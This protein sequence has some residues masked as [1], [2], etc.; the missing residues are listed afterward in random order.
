MS[1]RTARDMQ[2]DPVSK[3]KQTNKQTELRKE[4]GISCVVLLLLR[5]LGSQNL[6]KSLEYRI[7]LLI[8]QLILDQTE[9]AS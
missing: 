6:S 8:I 7:W 9:I 4:K 5:A 2:R 3:H 1:S